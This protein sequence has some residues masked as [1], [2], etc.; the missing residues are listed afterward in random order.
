MLYKYL[1]YYMSNGIMVRRPMAY[2][3]YW[4]GAAYTVGYRVGKSK[5]PTVDVGLPILEL[6]WRYNVLSTLDF[7]E[8]TIWYIIIQLLTF[9]TLDVWIRVRN[10]N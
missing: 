2:Q 4:Y 8:I 9:P 7:V 3:G 6:F 5:K 1:A 10:D